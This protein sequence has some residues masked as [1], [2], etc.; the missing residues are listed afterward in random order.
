MSGCQWAE[1]VF[2]VVWAAHSAV[3]SHRL[4]GNPQLS[5]CTFTAASVREEA[6]NFRNKLSTWFPSIPVDKLDG[7]DISSDDVLLA[8]DKA[9]ANSQNLSF[10]VLTA[11]PKAKTL[12]AYGMVDPDNPDKRI[13]FDTYEISQAI[14]EGFILLVHIFERRGNYEPLCH[15]PDAHD[16]RGIATRHRV[17]FLRRCPFQAFICC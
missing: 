12:A 4:R 7:E 14:E 2:V 11:T 16:R 9:V 6:F 10:I 5:A 8:M 15:S 17:C 3:G 1:D 13:A